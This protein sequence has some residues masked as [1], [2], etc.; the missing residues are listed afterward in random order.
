MSVDYCWRTCI[1]LLTFRSRGTG[2]LGY[3]LYAAGSMSS[4][5][6]FD[7]VCTFVLSGG[8]SR[9]ARVLLKVSEN[10]PSLILTDDLNDDVIS[11]C[12]KWAH[13]RRRS[14]PCPLIALLTCWAIRRQGLW[15]AAHCSTR[16]SSEVCHR[17]LSY[18]S[19]LDCCLY[20]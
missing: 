2:T 14:V 8:S 5:P 6:R 9:G 13:Q 20:H 16:H 18:A 17:G 12:F 15:Q 11:E 3:V 7:P 19:Y 4:S 10:S 1:S